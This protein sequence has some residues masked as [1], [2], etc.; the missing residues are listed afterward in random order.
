MLF[1]IVFLV[2]QTFEIGDNEKLKNFIPP[3]SHAEP[4]ISQT[5]C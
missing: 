5:G 2:F 4:E 1:I 3:Y